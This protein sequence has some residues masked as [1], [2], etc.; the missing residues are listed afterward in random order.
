MKPNYRVFLTILLAL[1]VG[2]SACQPAGT[3]PS[4]TPIPSPLASATSAPTLA[5]SATAT[6]EPSPTTEPSPTPTRVVLPEPRP[7]D[8]KVDPS[9]AF[10]RPGFEPESLDPAQW[11]GSADGIIGDLFGGLVRLDANLQVVPD[12]AE[13]WELSPDGLTYTFHLRRNATFH[14]GR[15]FTAA[16]VEFSWTRAASPETGSPTA[17]TYLTDIVGVREVLAGEATSISGLRTLD[18]YTIQVTLDAPK[19]FFLHKLAYPTSW[20][21]DYETVDH[22]DENPNGTGPFFLMQYIED[23]RY[24]LGRNTNYHAGPVYLEYVVYV[25]YYGNAARAYEAGTIDFAPISA[26]LVSRAENPGDPLYG[27][28]LSALSP[29]TSLIYLD[30]SVPPFDDLN[31]RLAFAQAVDKA[32]LNE[33]FY[34]GRATEASGVLPPGLPGYTPEVRGIGYDPDAARASLAASSYGGAEN[35]PEIVLTTYG[36]G[37]NLN[38]FDAALIQMW[39]EV[40][41]VRV[42]AEQLPN[43]TYWTDVLAGKHG[44]IVTSGWCADY[45]DPENFTDVLFRTGAPQNIGRYSNPEVEALMDRALVEIDVNQRL[46]LYAQIQQMLVDDV[47]AIFL[48]HSQPRYYVVNPRVQGF[49]NPPIGIS[50]NMNVTIQEPE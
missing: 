29:C 32:R 31:V 37:T 49:V 40:L 45:P 8:G 20:I 3:A 15:P 5:P 47:A 46:A 42:R 14:N 16:D 30:S 44:Q 41:G 12:L 39:R 26:D 21:V 2:L 28:V 22:I 10:F 34:D 1:A 50:Q 24:V 6:I 38:A 13:S 17:G 7:V 4:P 23:E 9:N 36:A 33:S 18:D 19:P 48:V 25:L 27:N 43:Q 35:L 11:L